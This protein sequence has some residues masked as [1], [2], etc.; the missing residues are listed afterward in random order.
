MTGE[1]ATCMGI[2]VSFALRHAISA[3]RIDSGIS[4]TQWFQIGNNILS[5]VGLLYV[6]YFLQTI[7]KIR[8][9]FNLKLKLY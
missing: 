2:A 4:P 7:D 3:A 5:F 6:C 8:I 9:K 1:P